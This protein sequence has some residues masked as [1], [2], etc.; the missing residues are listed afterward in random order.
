[1]VLRR[2]DVP[3]METACICDLPATSR[4]RTF[5]DLGRRLPLVESVAVLD[6]ALHHR[7]VRVDELVYWAYAHPR[8]RGISHL[9]RALD[10][11]EPATESPMETRLRLLLIS[12]GLPKPSV[13]S[14]IYDENG[15][16]VARADLCYQAEGLVIEYDGLTHR[17][18]LAADN[19]RQNLLIEA[20][21]RVLRFTAGDILHRPA[22]VVAQVGRA[23]L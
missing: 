17:T 13:Q 11:T 19:R 23:L 22:S 16:F 9:R 1:M 14:S 12:H 6:M 5:A 20:G 3:E 4:V 18:R 8:Y 7:L 2:S 15:V 21:Y 10:L